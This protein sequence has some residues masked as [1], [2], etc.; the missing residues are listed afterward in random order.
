MKQLNLFFSILVVSLISFFLVSCEKETESQKEAFSQD[1]YSSIENR[2]SIQKDLILKALV[3]EFHQEKISNGVTD[4]DILSAIENEN[5][6]ELTA[7][8]QTERINTLLNA[9]YEIEPLPSEYET[10]YQNIDLDNHVNIIACADWEG[11]ASCLG[12][13]QW[14]VNYCL[15]HINPDCQYYWD[16]IRWLKYECYRKNC[17]AA[18]NGTF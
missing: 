6:S 17:W 3:Y 13:L 8:Y 2:S 1:I 12:D 7:Y 11:F 16:N 15:T 5:F 10:Y 14:W 4:E 18:G 9:Y